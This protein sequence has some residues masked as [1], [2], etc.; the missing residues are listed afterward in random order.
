MHERGGGPSLSRRKTTLAFLF[1][2]NDMSQAPE[3]RCDAANSIVA[4]LAGNPSHPYVGDRRGAQWTGAA[5]RY[6]SP[7]LLSITYLALAEHRSPGR[8]LGSY[9]MVIAPAL[10]VHVILA[11]AALAF[12]GAVLLGAF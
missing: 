1:R 9:D 5:R 10:S 8:H 6:S 7:V 12:V 4:M 11:F 2:S 3:P